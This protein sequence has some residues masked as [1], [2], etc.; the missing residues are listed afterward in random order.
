MCF[1][2]IYFYLYSLQISLHTSELA[3][4]GHDPSQVVSKAL[5]GLNDFGL[6]LHPALDLITLEMIVLDI[7]SRFQ[8]LFALVGQTLE[9]RP[10][11]E[12]DEEGEV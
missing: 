9:I 3:L 2:F 4:Q 8:S 6:L 10:P 1:L 12:E 7:Q 5:C 11:S